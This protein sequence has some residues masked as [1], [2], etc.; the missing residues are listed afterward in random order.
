[1]FHNMFVMVMLAIIMAWS[2]KVAYQI[3]TAL[4]L[5]ARLLHS[6]PLQLEGMSIYAR[7]FQV[8]IRQHFNQILRIRRTV[9]PKLVTRHEISAHLLP[10]SITC[11]SAEPG[12]P[13]GFGV[14]FTVDALAPCCVRLYWGVSVQ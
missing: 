3:M 9:P 10:E 6:Q 8:I 7:D 11:V 13:A 2:V 14:E 5:N 12:C 4:D 1:D